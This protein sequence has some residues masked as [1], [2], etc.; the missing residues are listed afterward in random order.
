M[1]LWGLWLPLVLAC[2]GTN[3]VAGPELTEAERIEASLP[4]WCASTCQ[5][6]LMCWQDD[7]RCDGDVCECGPD[8]SCEEN[9]RSLLSSV[10]RTSAACAATAKRLQQCYDAA[11]CRVYD[12]DRPCRDLEDQASECD[13]TYYGSASPPD[14][15]DPPPSDVP[16][17]TAGSANLGPNSGP[18]VTCAGGFGGGQ[19]LPQPG[20]TAVICE[21]GSFDCSDG[22]D[23]S[24][25]C[26]AT[27][28]GQRACSCIVDAVVTGA[29]TPG[30]S[31][32]TREEMNAGCGW[33]L[34][35]L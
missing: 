9:C 30:E 27:S 1:R 34:A 32:P 6:L 31:C 14:P 33:R 35:E 28:S 24:M 2:S 11:G 13:P 15:P 29:F 10:L 19:G 26:V 22:R 20:S 8:D 25:V 3:V 5:S 17:G 4:A 12:S 16:S 7:C 23:Y 18:E 21:E